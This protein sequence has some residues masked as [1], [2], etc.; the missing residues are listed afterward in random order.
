MQG[1]PPAHHEPGPAKPVMSTRGDD[2]NLRK[3]L[4]FAV[5]LAATGALVGA[6]V[7]LFLGVLGRTTAENYPREF[8]LAPIGTYRLPPEPRLQVQ[9][10]EDLKRMRAEEDT[11]LNSYGW[12]DRGAGVVRIPVEQAMKKLVDEGLP[13]RQPP[14]EASPSP[15]TPPLP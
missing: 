5:G 3:V 8:P 11:V 14:V 4:G 15:Q 2:I 13:A 10:R 7:W 6:V 9:P 12:V 1:E